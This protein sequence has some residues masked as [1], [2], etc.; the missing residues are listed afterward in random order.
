M[1]QLHFSI[2]MVSKLSHSPPC[3]FQDSHKDHFRGTPWPSLLSLLGQL[4]QAERQYVE[5]TFLQPRGFL[6]KD[7][8]LKVSRKK[9]EAT[10]CVKE[11]EGLIAFGKFNTRNI[12]YVVYT[13]R[14][15]KGVSPS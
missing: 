15:D 7:N 2:K 6:R 13:Y 3:S 8:S 5:L 10:K 11:V 12:P 9:N 14:Q 1:F 4:T